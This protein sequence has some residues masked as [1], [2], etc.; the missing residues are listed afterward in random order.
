MRYIASFVFV[1]GLF[2]SLPQVTQA[3][4]TATDFITTWDTENTGTSAS[5]QITIPGTGSGYSYSI[6]WESLSSST[7]TGTIA[8]STSASQT[9]TFPEAG[10]YKVGIKGTYPR[11]YFNN[12]GDK[13]KIL[14]VEQWGDK[15]WT[16]MV[17]AF[18]GCTNLTVPATDA[19]NLS[20]VTSMS[21]MFRDSISFNDSI[22]HWN[23]SNINTLYGVFWGASSFNQPLDSWDISNVTSIDSTF[24]AA[25]SF[26][27]ALN[28]WDTSK[29]I[30]MNNTFNSATNFNK[31]LSNWNTASTTG[32]F[33]MFY[34]TPFNQPL[35]TWD[36][37]NVTSMGSMFQD[38]TFFNQPLNTWDVSNVVS[39]GGMFRGSSAFNQSLS[40]WDT[41]KVTNM[42]FL[43]YS[44]AFNQDLSTWN[45]ASTT[46]MTNMFLNV[47]LSE[48]NLDSTLQGWAGQSLKTNVPLHLGLKTY[49]STGS[50]ALNTLRNTY[51]WTITEQYQAEY[52]D[53][54]NYSLSGTTTQSPITSGSSTTAIE[55]IPNNRCTFINWSDGNTTNPRTDTLTDNLTVSANVECTSPVSG[56][57]AS[58]RYRKLLEYGK[59]TEAEA[60]KDKY[61]TTHTNTI[62]TAITTIATIAT[63]AS[64][65]AITNN[66]QTKQQL[67]SLLTQLVKVLEGMRGG[68]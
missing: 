17:N 24:R 5:N 21:Q 54:D 32:M 3:S 7:A 16:S 55:V 8:T 51:N 46:S 10:Q 36:V 28:S 33:A 43:F 42:S 22:N 6:Y 63:L 48:S 61:F 53:G 1:I 26:N 59:T 65:P 9:I 35:N 15:A 62:Q 66:P 19:P 41:S 4:F 56:N 30:S 12:G 25:T 29:V 39:L 64:N 49:S 68:G 47:A 60:I 13:L 50:T 27:Q 23:V 14:T 67:I 11:I 37:S 52:Q 58:S 34:M 2:I 45:L 18:Y 44:T 38:N 31:D 20:G 40:S 57:N